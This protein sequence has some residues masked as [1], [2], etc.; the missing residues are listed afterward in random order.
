MPINPMTNPLLQ[1]LIPPKLP[2]QLAHILEIQERQMKALE[3]LNE[4]MAQMQRK[5]FET[6][7][8]AQIVHLHYPDDPSY[9]TSEKLHIVGLLWTGDDAGLWEML[10]GEANIA[11]YL[12][13]PGGVGQQTQVLDLSGVKKLTVA[14]GQRIWLRQASGV[15]TSL[16][17]TIISIPS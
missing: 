15:A 2:E 7:P 3:A 10:I 9:V 1:S 6:E 5:M 12:G 11:L 8:A 4:S 16:T 17:V 13:T 14:R